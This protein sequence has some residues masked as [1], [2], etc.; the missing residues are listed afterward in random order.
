[1]A[2]LQNADDVALHFRARRQPTHVVALNFRVPLDLRR[3]LKL[4]AALR[5]VSMTD[6]G[7]DAIQQYLAMSRD[8]RAVSACNQDIQQE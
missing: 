4:E 7:I 8:S 1:M 3:Q 5:G 2:R 6:L